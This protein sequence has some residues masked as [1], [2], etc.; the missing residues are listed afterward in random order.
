MCRIERSLENRKRGNGQ[1]RPLFSPTACPSVH[2]VTLGSSGRSLPGI[3]H[4]VACCR[5][6]VR[7][8]ALGALQDPRTRVL[9]SISSALRISIAKGGVTVDTLG[10]SEHS[11]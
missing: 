8:V 10:S 9:V 3:E 7:Q 6:D 4:L 11:D 2:S 5:L 1:G